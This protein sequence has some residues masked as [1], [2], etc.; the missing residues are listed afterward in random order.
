MPMLFGG[1]VGIKN[2]GKALDGNASCIV[3]NFNNNIF[4]V[5]VDKN[6]NQTSF[7]MF[8]ISALFDLIFGIVDDVEQ[9]LHKLVFIA[10]DHEIGGMTY[11]NS[12][13]NI[14]VFNIVIDDFQHRINGI[15]DIKKSL[16]R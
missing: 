5:I 9:G 12:D 10:D 14:V 15:T 7:N 13:I 1:E 3:V 6:M 11:I 16:L 2:I 4:G 8:E